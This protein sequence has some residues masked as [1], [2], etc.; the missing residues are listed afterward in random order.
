MHDGR[1]LGVGAANGVDGGEFADT[2]GGDEGAEAFDARVAV[3]GVGSVE[4]IAVSY[5]EE[6]GGGD[7]V[8]GGEVVVAGDAVEGGA[9]ELVEA[10]VEVGC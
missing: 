4:L 7:M 1:M 10:G 5:P 6:V 3:G 8:E 2:E 9:V